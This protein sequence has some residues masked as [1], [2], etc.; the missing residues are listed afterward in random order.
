MREGPPDSRELGHYFSL[1]Q[2]GLEMVFPL[3]VGVVLDSYFGWKP[4]ATIA[5]IGFG[6]VGGL[7]HLIVLSNRRDAA[8]RSK[9]PGGAP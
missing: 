7:V 3:I 6:F 4:W 5:G 8:D 1:A 2:V 9:P